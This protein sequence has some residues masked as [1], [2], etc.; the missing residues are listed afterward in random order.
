MSLEIWDVLAELDRA[1]VAYYQPNA[2]AVL[3]PCVV[4]PKEMNWT[5][6]RQR[7]VCA[8]RECPSQEYPSAIANELHFRSS[9]RCKGDVT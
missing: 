1:G 3:A 7:W 5:D 2:K 9:Y 4:C 6:E 8:S